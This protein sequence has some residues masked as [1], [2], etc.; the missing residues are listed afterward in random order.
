[1]EFD[2]LRTQVLYISEEL[3]GHGHVT[4]PAL[5]AGDQQEDVQEKYQKAC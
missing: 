2:T 5:N 1:M 4:A 3:A